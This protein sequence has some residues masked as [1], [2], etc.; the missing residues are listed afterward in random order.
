MQLF[1][2]RFLCLTFKLSCCQVQFMGWNSVGFF[3]ATGED[4]YTHS[5]SGCDYLLH[6][7]LIIEKK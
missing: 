4:F 2:I 3:N 7:V 1:F 6:A 5:F